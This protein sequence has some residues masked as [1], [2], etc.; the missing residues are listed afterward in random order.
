MAA[1]C[2]TTLIVTCL[3]PEDTLPS[4]ML[5]IG[6]LQCQNTRHLLLVAVAFE[7]SAGLGKQLRFDHRA[8]DL[9]LVLVMPYIMTCIHYK[10]HMVWPRIEP[11]L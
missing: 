11:S 9:T 1:G 5:C 2:S 7:V 6:K 3:V 10:S 4:S 8:G